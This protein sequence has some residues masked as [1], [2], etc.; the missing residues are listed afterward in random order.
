MRTSIKMLSDKKQGGNPNPLFSWI[1]DTED[2]AEVQIKLAKPE[3]KVAEIG[4]PRFPKA[5]GT[6]KR[7]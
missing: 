3:V 7:G 1:G 5:S 6:R 2:M 4:T